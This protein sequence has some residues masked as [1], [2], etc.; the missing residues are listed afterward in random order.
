MGM[1]IDGKWSERGYETEKHDGRFVRD[2]SLFRNWI[3]PDGAPGPTGT[4][5]FAAEAGRYRL[6]VS[7]A[8][9]WASR[10]LIFRNLKGLA[11]MIPVSVVNPWMGPRGWSF[12][13]APGVV[14][15]PV[16]GAEYLSDLYVHARPDYTGRVTVPVLW[17]TRTDSIVSNESAD[18]IRMF[19]T[20]FDRVGAKPGDYYPADL[21]AEIDAINDRVYGDVNNGVYRAGFATKQDAY[22]EAVG[23]LFKTLDALEARLRT[24]RYLLGARL[25]EADWRL[26]TTLVRFDC[27]YAIHFKC[28]KRR[29]VDYPA[30]WGYTR[31]LFQM[32]GIAATV[33]F[34]HIKRHYYTSHPWLNPSGLIPDG[35]DP[36]FTAPHGRGHLAAKGA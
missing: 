24:R 17:D 19:N 33:D 15:D 34:D 12:D 20:A 11:E 27:V 35:P 5:G 13:A 1:L 23:T 8:C 32:H 18:I 2:E 4:G 21:R 25:T 29:L 14:A 16:I 22:E 9:P 3:T 36:D 10:A 7:L 6:Y 26:F 28:A 30:L 31:E